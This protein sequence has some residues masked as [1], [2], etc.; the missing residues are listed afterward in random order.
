[1]GVSDKEYE[2]TVPDDREISF[3]VEKESPWE[4]SKTANV[5]LA[6]SLLI[7]TF[8]GWSAVDSE[9]LPINIDY[10]AKFDG[11]SDI[12]L[13]LGDI[14][15]V[16]QHGVRV[17]KKAFIAQMVLFAVLIL[18]IAAVPLFVLPFPILWVFPF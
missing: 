16:D 6:F 4:E 17:W 7:S 13:L 15:A 10:P 3:S 1:M 12:T 2:M 14:I 9:Y 8:G 5:A 11:K 18:F